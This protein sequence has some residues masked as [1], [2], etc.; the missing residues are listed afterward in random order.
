[1]KLLVHG[2]PQSFGGEM[3]FVPVDEKHWQNALRSLRD[4]PVVLTIERESRKRTLQQNKRY[5]GAIV[6]AW[7]LILKGL[8]YREYD[9]QTAH[10]M[11]ASRFLTIEVFNNNTGEIIGRRVR[12]TTEL[13]TID[14]NNFM[15]QAEQYLLEEWGVTIEQRGEDN[16]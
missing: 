8:G 9:A 6:G 5:F 16:K 3:C 2:K 14:F 12:S 13:N 4:K 15:D 7:L 11:L 10:E 1:M